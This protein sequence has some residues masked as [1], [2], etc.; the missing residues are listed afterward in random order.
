MDFC[1]PSL[2]AGHMTENYQ[3]TTAVVTATNTALN[4]ASDDFMKDN[5]N[6]VVNIWSGSKKL[7]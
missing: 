7:I 4:M 3:Q 1:P 5:Q 2:R 6:I